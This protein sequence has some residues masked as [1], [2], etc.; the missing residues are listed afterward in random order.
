MDSPHTAQVISSLKQIRS[1]CGL[2]IQDVYNIA[3]EMGETISLSTVKRIFAD[4][5]ERQN[6][7]YIDSLAPIERALSAYKA[8]KAAAELPANALATQYQKQ[9][10]YLKQE[11]EKKDKM[12]S[13]RSRLTLILIAALV[14]FM[15]AVIV[16]LFIDVVN[17]N[18][19]WFRALEAIGGSA[20][21]A[22]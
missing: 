19:G 20:S 3:I 15:L 4:G 8:E 5:S 10:D 16:V 1:E 13:Q 7:R 17:P 21:A 9:I 18:I 6:F 14:L 2:T 11:I 22:V 12:I